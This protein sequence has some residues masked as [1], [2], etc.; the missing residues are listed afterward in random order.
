[1]VDLR[2]RPLVDDEGLYVPRRTDALVHRAVDANENVLLGAERGLGA[3]SML[4]RLA[5]STPDAVVINGDRADSPGEVLG[6]LAARLRLSRSLMPDFGVLVRHI[7]PLAAP[8]LL[9]QLRDA[10][11]E[12][13]RHPLLL[14]DGPLAPN[15]AFELFGRL[16]DDLFAI[17]ATWVVLAHADRMAEYL[18]PP[19][20]VFFELVT[21]IEPFD[22]VGASEVLVQRGMDPADAAPALAEFDGSPRH[23]LRLARAVDEQR[24]PEVSLV[25]AH[26]EATRAL[27]RGA[28]MLLAEMHGRGPVAA[29]DT[30]IRR[31][32]G[33]SDRQVRRNLVELEGAGLAEVV[34][35]G[36]GGPGRPPTVYQLTEIGRAQG[37]AA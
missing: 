12:A 23:L 28:Q 24:T 1:M 16:R 7:D 33:L 29:T 9:G 35:G 25:R 36:R 2:A 14:V 27:S 20:D 26:A 18:T 37:G 8:P 10:L 15:V 13:G 22:A 17:P 30:E 34:P 21:T 5:R 6:S 31:R 32:L 19:A 4:N 11:S 3:T